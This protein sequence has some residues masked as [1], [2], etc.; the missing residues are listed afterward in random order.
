M[1]A[2]KSVIREFDGRR[3]TRLTPARD[4]EQKC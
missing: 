3:G 2:G 1:D 4:A